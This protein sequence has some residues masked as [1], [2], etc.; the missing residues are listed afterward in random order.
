MGGTPY[1]PVKEGG[2]VLFFSVS[3]FNH[4]RAPMYAYSNSLPTNLLK[5]WINNNV[6]R[7]HGLGSSRPDGMQPSE[8]QNATVSVV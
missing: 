4:E 8:R 2:R 7:S 5:Y 6:Q 3:A 1:R